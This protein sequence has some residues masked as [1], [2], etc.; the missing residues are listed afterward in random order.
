MKPNSRNM[1]QP[2]DQPSRDTRPE[3]RPLTDNE[4]RTRPEQDQD[5]QE[6]MT[7]RSNLAGDQDVE[8]TDED[9]IDTDQDDNDVER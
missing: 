8:D 1:P 9:E 6:A 3:E 2:G 4:R 7:R 5:S